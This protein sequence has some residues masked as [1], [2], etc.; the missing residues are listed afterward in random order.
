MH[1]NRLIS[2]ARPEGVEKGGGTVFGRASA[3][4]HGPLHGNAGV[5]FWLGAV[6]VWEYV[7]GISLFLALSLKGEGTPVPVA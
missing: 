6:S 2:K 3:R 4:E 7:P 5:G 1:R